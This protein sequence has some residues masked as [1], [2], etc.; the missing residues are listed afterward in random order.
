MS[1]KTETRAI[2]SRQIRIRQLPYRE[3]RRVFLSLATLLGPALLDALGG[4]A[5]LADLRRGAVDPRAL[6]GGLRDLLGRLSDSALEDLCE[7]FGSA[8]EVDRG[9]GK[10][11][12]MHAPIRDEIFSGSLV[13]SFRW[14][15]ACVEVNYS[16]F[17][18]ALPG[19]SVSGQGEDPAR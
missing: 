14:L 11:A 1:I 2:G 15:V 8:C 3:A 5:S 4:A 18:T 17:L 16:D 13:D 19:P 6:S 10:W 7:A 9:G 12:T